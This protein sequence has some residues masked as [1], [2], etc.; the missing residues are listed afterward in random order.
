VAEKDLHW[1]QY[2]DIHADDIKIRGWKTRGFTGHVKA[3]TS[4]YISSQESF[5]DRRLL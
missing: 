2:V 5:I 1:K 4:E 3:I